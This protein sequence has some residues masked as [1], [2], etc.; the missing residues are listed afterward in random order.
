MKHFIFT[1]AFLSLFYAIPSMAGQLSLEQTD[2]QANR[3]EKVAT[4]D[5]PPALSQAIATKMQSQIGSMA[6]TILTLQAQLEQAQ[7]ENAALRAAKA[8][9]EQ[10]HPKQIQRRSADEK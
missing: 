2:L 1:I 9:C 5:S 10:S 7:Q 3:I 4:E 6:V 8:K